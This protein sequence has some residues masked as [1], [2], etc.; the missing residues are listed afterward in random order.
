MGFS[1]S[2]STPQQCSDFTIQWSGGTPPY[3]LV[4][5]PTITVQ[6]GRIINMTLPDN[7]TNPYSYTFQLEEPTGL[8]FMVA[9]SDATG[10]GAGGTTSVLTVGSSSDSSCLPSALNYDFFFSI[11]PNS[12]PASCTSM[13]VSWPENAT[14]PVS[15]YGLIPHG[16]AFQVPIDQ[17]SLSHNWQVDI[18]PNTQ[19]L[20]LMSDEGQY[21]TGGST[22]LYQ[23][24]NGD[25]GC[26]S[27]TSPSASNGDAVTS[28]TSATA[29]PS[30]SVSGVGGSS[31][32]GT[33][34]EGRNSTD[35]GAIVGGV[36][37]GV[38]FLVLLALL[39]CFCVR[40]R[41]GEN[42]S[43]R[44]SD[45][46]RQSFIKSYGLAGAVE[47]NRRSN[48]LDLVD[49]DDAEQG[50]RGRPS[51]EGL[52]RN[53]QPVEGEGDVYEPSPFR[54]PSP[55]ETPG[56]GGNLGGT[57]F[58]GITHSSLNTPEMLALGNEKLAAHARPESVGGS[59]GQ[60]TPTRPSTDSANV[61]HSP[62]APSS[63]LGG[64]AT[65]ASGQATDGN[66]PGRMSSIRK[67]PRGQTAPGVNPGSNASDAVAEGTR[68]VQHEDA[69]VIDLP[70]RYDQLRARNP[71][72]SE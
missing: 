48:Q 12:A 43:R 53:G 36:V 22:P 41:R 4:I 5:V 40:R 63:A 62:L 33:S 26:V 10:F 32:G 25:T 57:R 50:Q 28:A 9:M 17:S 55:T 31:S 60:G 67:A 61:T 56:Q 6:G 68:F 72:P 39:L 42:G 18:K 71:D 1:F 52:V 13:T 47:K 11:D 44:G 59:T 45:G 35:V 16:S 23:V 51:S 30:S 24:Q 54:Y 66:G 3:Q 14:E 65:H 69:G 27:S 49:S 7:L 15:L 37:G 2:T 21:K 29:A 70:P 64:A 8:E 46:S 58:S 19:F 34:A 20:L 38:A